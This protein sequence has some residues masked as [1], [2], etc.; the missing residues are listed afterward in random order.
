MN[1]IIAAIVGL[2]MITTPALAYCPG[3]Y[4][5]PQTASSQFSLSASG[6]TSVATLS[7]IAGWDGAFRASVIE[8]ICNDGDIG[9]A[10]SVDFSVPSFGAS[11]MLESK[12]VEAYG[13]TEIIKGVLWNS[14][15]YWPSTANLYIGWMTPTAS[16]EVDVTNVGSGSALYSMDTNSP[17]L[18]AES[19]GFNTGTDCYPEPPKIPIQPS[20]ECDTFWGICVC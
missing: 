4:T 20:C 16:D 8:N 11:V 18:Y 6:L 15:P 13:D 14:H 7:T 2:L 19:F 1:K 5:P 17:L 12:N 10:T 9:M 3:C